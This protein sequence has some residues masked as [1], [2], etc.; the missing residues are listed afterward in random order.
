MKNFLFDFRYAPFKQLFKKYWMVL[1]FSPIAISALLV[2]LCGNLWM[3]MMAGLCN[4]DFYMQYF[5]EPFIRD[6]VEELISI[7]IIGFGVFYFLVFIE[8]VY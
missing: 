1:I 6:D 8:I 2:I 3:A 5:P 4:I 7:P